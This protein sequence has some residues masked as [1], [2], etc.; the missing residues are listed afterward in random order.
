MV[1]KD[2][3]EEFIC[4]KEKRGNYTSRKEKAFLNQKK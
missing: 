3:P 1:T 4:K 2:N